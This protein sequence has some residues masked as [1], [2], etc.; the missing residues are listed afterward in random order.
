MKALFKKIF[1]AVLGLCYCMWA[2]SSCGVR[3]PHCSGFSSC[4]AQSVGT[5][6]VAVVPWRSYS[7]ACGIFPDQGSNLCP[8]HMQVDS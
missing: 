5:G 6:S 3:A 8:L 1:L 2:L 7:V 4:G